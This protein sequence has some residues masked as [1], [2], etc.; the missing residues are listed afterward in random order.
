MK[1]ENDKLVLE[2]RSEID[3]L[4][5][6]IAVYLESGKSI[7]DADRAELQHIQHQLDVLYMTW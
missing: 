2:S 3:K 1:I 6:M 4:Q 7:S 5:E